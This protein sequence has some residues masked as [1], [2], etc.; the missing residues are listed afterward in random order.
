MRVHRKKLI[1]VKWTGTVLCTFGITLTSFNV[2]PLNIFVMFIGTGIW[3]VA[4]MLQKDWPLASGEL[5]SLV[6]YGSGISFFLFQ[7]FFR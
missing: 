6:L 1:P 7:M 3:F 4:G 5:I 2:Y